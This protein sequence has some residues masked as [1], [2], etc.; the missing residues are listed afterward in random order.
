ML[1]A[2]RSIA[3]RATHRASRPRRCSSGP[4]KEDVPMP[5]RAQLWRLALVNGV[6]FVGFGIADNAI[7]IVAGDVIDK[8]IGVTLGI[9]TLAAAGLGNLLS[10]VV[11]IGAGD[12]ID[13]YSERIIGKERTK[14]LSLEQLALRKCRVV[15]TWATVVGVSI[16][17]LI[18]ML[19][20]LF[21]GEK[22]ELYFTGEEMALYES[23][24]RPY[25]V[26]PQN[27]FSM[28]KMGTWKTLEP[29]GAVVRAGE[30]MERIA[31]VASGSVDSYETLKDGS[32]KRL[33]R[34]RA[35]QDITTAGAAQPALPEDVQR[36]VPVRGCV[37][38]G[39]ALLDASVRLQPYPSTCLAAERTRIVEF[40]YADLRKD[41]D[42]NPAIEAAILN[43]LYFD[44][45]EGLRR[46][47][48]YDYGNRPERAKTQKAV[49]DRLA[50]YDVLLA[51]AL[52]DG[53]V[54]AAEREV[55]A[56]YALDHAISDA[57]HAAGLARR[58]WTEAQWAAGVQVGLAAGGTGAIKSSIP[59]LL[60]QAGVKSRLVGDKVPVLEAPKPPPSGMREA[61]DR[62]NSKL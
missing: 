13:R 51:L 19:P 21:L 28:M 47:G 42:E 49:E 55:L 24:L 3:F 43:I 8:S 12:V 35:K 59:E 31:L 26:S 17:C 15:K 61:F 57:E 52:A 45:V 54:H 25:G 10:D 14:P 37:I 5:S 50:T 22:K 20:L 1:R 46:R 32:L 40:K 16:G 41:M 9:S 62:V 58:G 11:G 7:M 53:V 30:K 39:T 33:Y 27:F 29:G 44:L 34:Y 38:G 4:P 18:G 6:P 48:Q 23:A 60:K 36:R 56:K 2:T